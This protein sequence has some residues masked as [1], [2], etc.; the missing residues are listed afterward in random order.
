MELGTKYQI[1]AGHSEDLG[2]ANLLWGLRDPLPSLDHVF[3]M[4]T[5][6]R[7]GRMT[8]KVPPAEQKGPLPEYLAYAHVL[9]GVIPLCS[10]FTKWLRISPFCSAEFLRPA[11]EV[12][13]CLEALELSAPPAEPL[14]GAS[15]VG[16]GWHRRD[17]MRWEGCMAAGPGRDPTSVGQATYPTFHCCPGG[18]PCPPRAPQFSPFL[19]LQVGL[20]ITPTPALP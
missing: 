14:G 15:W 8:S 7:V 3:P 10:D 18:S 6:R 20:I 4:H 12:R 17:R 11:G 9:T 1:G 16:V 13:V 19:Q 2:Q 5:P